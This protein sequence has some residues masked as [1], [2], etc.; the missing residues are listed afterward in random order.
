M[1]V[2][3]PISVSAVPLSPGI[4]FRRSSKL[5][6]AMLRSLCDLLGGLGRF[7]LVLL[8]QPW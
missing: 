8:C 4:D 7:F 5:L 2:D 6:G 1:R 3:R